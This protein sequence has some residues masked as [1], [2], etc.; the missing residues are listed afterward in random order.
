MKWL[1]LILIINAY[2]LKALEGCTC[3]VFNNFYSFITST[4]TTNKKTHTKATS[5]NFQF[6]T[7]TTLPSIK[8]QNPVWIQ[9]ILL[10]NEPTGCTPCFFYLLTFFMYGYMCKLQTY[11][12]LQGVR[13]GGVSEQGVKMRIGSVYSY[14]MVSMLCLCICKRLPHSLPPPPQHS[15]TSSPLPQRQKTLH[16]IAKTLYCSPASRLHILQLGWKRTFRVFAFEMLFVGFGIGH[17]RHTYTT[18][19][20]ECSIR[21]SFLRRSFL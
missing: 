7:Q 11:Y 4:K 10:K 13:W 9:N 5:P 1:S 16:C 15:S 14:V 21:W 19:V 8:F 3:K 18:L 17:S 12:L 20:N 6:T 2:F